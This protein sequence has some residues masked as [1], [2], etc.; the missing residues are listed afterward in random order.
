LFAI[1]ADMKSL[2]IIVFC[3]MMQGV[4]GQ[5]AF[6]HTFYN[7]C[8]LNYEIPMH[9]K[10]L[11]I[12]IVESENLFE[13]HVE[14]PKGTSSSNSLNL[15]MRLNGKLAG[16]YP[17]GINAKELMDLSNSYDGT[18]SMTASIQTDCGST[19]VYSKMD[20]TGF[21]ELTDV[22]STHGISG[23]CR[24]NLNGVE[25]FMDFKNIKTN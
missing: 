10:S 13:I 21:I 7:G 25:F 12:G 3:F 19:D 17:V 14:V 5:R 2:A 4:S 11:R 22:S 1:Q 18:A 15:E 20:S 6:L 16:K 9:K 24:V 8:S 23:Y